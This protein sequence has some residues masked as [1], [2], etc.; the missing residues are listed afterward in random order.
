MWVLRVW[1]VEGVPGLRSRGGKKVD[2]DEV[3]I[4]LTLWEL[5]LLRFGFRV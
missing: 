2:G 1:S 4:M 5:E 3:K